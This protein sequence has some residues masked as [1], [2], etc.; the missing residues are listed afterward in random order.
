[1]TMRATVHGAHLIQ[2]TNYPLLFPVNCYLVREAD[3]F[4]L[5]DTGLPGN[6]PAIIAEARARGG[7]IRRIALTHAHMDHMSSLDALHDALPDAEVLLTARQERLLAGDRSLD[8]TEQLPGAKLRGSWRD[9]AARATRPIAAGGRVGSLRIVAA[10]GHTPDHLA[11]FDP[12]D[13]TLIA[14]DAFQTRGGVAVSG[15]IRPLFPFP[16]LGTWHKPTALASARALR[17]LAPARLAIG[18]GPVLEDPLEA[19]GKAIA[20]A[21]RGGKEARRV[22]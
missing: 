10:P 11:F 13:G 19:I 14:G 16:G 8:A 3:G 7:A 6:A 17:D 5:I 4:T 20:T 18:H 21:A 22:P 1:M 9:A 2:L 12:R 15:I